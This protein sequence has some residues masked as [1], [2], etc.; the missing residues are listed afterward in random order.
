MI[1]IT[2][3]S[4]RREPGTARSEAIA[5]FHDILPAAIAA[6]P[7]GLVFGALATAK[8]LSVGEVWL[9]SFLVCAGGAQFAAIELWSYPVPTAALIASTLLINSR[10]VLMSASLGPK[11]SAFRPWQRFLTMFVMSD[12]NWAFAE[13][14][15]TTRRL[16]PAYFGTMGATLW[17]NW[18]VS[19]TLGAVGGSF[20]G[21]P[22]AIG[23]DFAFTALFIGVVAGMWR[24][25]ATAAPVLAS[26]AVGA[27][28]YHLIG[29]PWHVLTGA[30]AGIAT[31]AAAVRSTERAR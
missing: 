18:Q 22:R 8:G 9:M 15:A 2:S 4:D 24:G 7:I 30:F 21:D 23:A 28:T 14:R 16:T 29:T 27:V 1:E 26:A 31:A 25:P 6:L 20:L 17:I 12:E 19:S 11:T 10:H 5:G 13:R 3:A